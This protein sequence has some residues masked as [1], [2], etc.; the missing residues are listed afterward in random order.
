V[1][2]G[3][4]VGADALRDVRVDGER[5]APAAFPDDAQRVEAPVL[6]Q[7]LHRE[8]GDFRAAEAHRR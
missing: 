5:V 8:R 1:A 3:I 2:G 4:E 7:V 6:M